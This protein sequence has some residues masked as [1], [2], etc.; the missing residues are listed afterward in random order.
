MNCPDCG[1]LVELRV[2]RGPFER[3]RVPWLVDPDGS[4]M[5]RHFCPPPE[6][7]SEQWDICTCGGRYV[8]VNG[9][10]R[11]NLDYTPHACPKAEPAPTQR[12]R[13]PSIEAAPRPALAEVGMEI[14]R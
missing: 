2:L 11:L 9:G 3:R 8:R 7:E 14:P 5:R 4:G 1:A 10:D 13:I 6:I 12:Q